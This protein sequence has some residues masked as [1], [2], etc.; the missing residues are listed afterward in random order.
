MSALCRRRPDGPRGELLEHGLL[1]LLRRLLSDLAADHPQRPVLQARGE[2]RRARPDHPGL[3]P[4]LHG[5][6]GARRLLRRAGDHSLRHHGAALR[7]L[8]RPDAPD[9][10]CHRPCGG[11]G[12]VRYPDLRFR[13]QTGA[14]AGGLRQG[15][16]TSR[17]AVAQIHDHRPC[18]S[19]GGDRRRSV[20]A[21]KLPPRRPGMGPVRQ[22]GRG[23]RGEYGARRGELRRSKRRCR[24]CANDPG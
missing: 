11:P 3:R 22:Q 7:R 17:Q 8:L 10:P 6:A 18:R 9:P 24:C 12:H 14:A 2:S 20:S 21:G 15:K 5:Y 16:G 1:R 13:G 19:G 4:R 23:L